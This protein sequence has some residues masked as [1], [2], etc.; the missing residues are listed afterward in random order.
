MDI[1][2]VF[3]TK[4]KVQKAVL[5]VNLSTIGDYILFRNFLE[6][7]KKE[8]NEFKIVLCGNIIWKELSEYFDKPYVDEFIWVDVH[9]FV[10]NLL[11]R[12][13]ILKKARACAYSIALHPCYSRS[14]F[15]GDQIIKNVV[16][17]G[18]IGSK[19]EKSSFSFFKRW[20]SDRYYTMLV[21]TPESNIFEFDRYRLFFE[22]LF[23]TKLPV[24]K[25]HLPLLSI[26]NPVKE[27][28]YAIII[29]GAGAKFREWNPKN[30]AE[31]VNFL[32]DEF[33]YKCV[34]LGSSKDMDLANEI[35]HHLKTDNVI[36]MVGR[37]GF[38]QAVR[39]IQDSDLVIANET[40]IVHIGAALNK[41][42]LCLSNGNH[43]GRFAPYPL[44][45][46]SDA[47]YIFPEQIAKSLDRLDELKEKYRY[48]SRIDINSIHPSVVKN[49]IVHLLIAGH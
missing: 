30:F 40:G 5:V 35:L 19:C 20:T 31:V 39:I 3:V 9:K 12:F 42:L 4:P 36:N 15:L 6:Y 25:P 10:N 46:Y 49:E 16:A 48:G 7:T 1:F 14:F 8:Y 34:L 21:N 24:N 43:F 45:I 47:H 29:P 18:K 44:S 22:D 37:I 41:K 17:K 2:L 13:A 23:R 11:Y 33:S 28:H 38:L 26:E 27:K 32:W